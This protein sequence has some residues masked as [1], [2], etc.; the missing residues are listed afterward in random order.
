VGARVALS[1]LGTLPPGPLST[2]I[3]A[4]DKAAISRANGV[5]GK[6]AARIVAELKDRVGTAATAISLGVPAT[7]SA[8]GAAAEA[9]SALVNLGYARSEAFA[10]VGRVQARL[11]EGA[12]VD[13]V[14]RESLRE[15]SP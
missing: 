13:A 4:G 15:L 5:G 11:G 7:T 8:E 14:L 3:V 10:A 12:P 9:L 1:V 2:A 6:L